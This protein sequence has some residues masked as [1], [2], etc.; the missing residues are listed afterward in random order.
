MSFVFHEIYDGDTGQWASMSYP[1][2]ANPL[3]EM[4]MLLKKLEIIGQDN[5]FRSGGRELRL[6]AEVANVSVL[7]G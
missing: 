7:N 6:L 5:I 4:D 3:Q 1:I 2:L